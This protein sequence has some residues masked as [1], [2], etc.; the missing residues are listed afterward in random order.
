[1]QEQNT[2]EK[3]QQLLKHKKSMAY[4]AERLQIPVE[5]V[6]ELMK[7]LRTQG[8]P[9]QEEAEVATYIGE[10]EEKIVEQNLEKGTLKSSI[11]VDYEPKDTDQLYELHK[12]DK[13]KFKITNYWSKLKSSGKFTSSVFATSKKSSEY[14]ADDFAKFLENYT[15][16]ELDIPKSPIRENLPLVDLELSIADFHLAKK[17]LEGESIKTKK[18]Q[19]TEIAYKLISRAWKSFNIGKTVFVVSNDFFHTDNYQNQT[20]N[21]TPQDV[22]TTYDHEYEEGFDLLVGVISMLLAYSESVEV[23]LVQGNHD[24]TKSFY[25]THALEVFF[26]ANRNISFQRHHSTTKSVVRGDNL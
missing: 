26:S 14:T 12:I 1:M 3:L 15:P 8:N 17:T 16:K 6:K 18:E 20:T 25:L 22:L 10:L 7:E 21:G 9:V 4:Y 5:E 23:I 19:Y 24:R 11:V 2:L 13:T